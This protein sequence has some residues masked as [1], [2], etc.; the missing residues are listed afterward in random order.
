M[1]HRVSVEISD[2][3]ADV[4]LD[5]PEKLN[6]LDT[7]M[8][9]ALART[10]Q[11]LAEDRSL[12][13]VVLSGNGRS[14]CAGLD[15]SGFAAMAERRSSTEGD[16]VGS[17]AKVPEGR[18]THLG[19]QAVWTWQELPVPVLVAV[20]GHALGGG[21]QLA[22]GGDI[23]FV[24]PEARM[25]ILEI[26]WGIVPDMCAS[27]LLPRLVG[28]DVAKELYFTGR[29]VAG[30][31]AAQLGLATH[32]SD[33]PHGDAMAMAREIAAKSPDAIRRDKLLLNRWDID[34]VA[35]AFAAERAHVGALAGSPN[36]VEAATAFLEKRDPVFEFGS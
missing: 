26:R 24:H 32:V 8:F 29:M 18:I 20:T 10:G 21:C 36:Q 2:G 23:R 7:A 9:E 34:D 35:A 15:F 17:I 12:R 6:A 3:I 27:V 25:S 11:E 33:D 5:R 16:G 13:A 4:R 30:E 1:E 14:F 31:E 28:N 19:Q 22:L